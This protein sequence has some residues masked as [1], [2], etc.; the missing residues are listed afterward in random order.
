METGAID[1][2]HRNG[3]A[4]HSDLQ[5]PILKRYLR[6]CREEGETLMGSARLDWSRQWE[7]PFVLANLPADGI[8]RRILD[9]GC[10]YRFFAPL[11]A[12]RGFDV[13]ACDLDAS[14]GP[15]YDEVAARFDIAIEFSQ[16]DLAKLAY[17]DERFDHICCISVLEHAHDPVAIIREFRRCLKVG[18][19]LLLTFD[20]SVRGDRDIPVA[21]AR[22]LVDLLEREFAFVTPFAHRSLF[23]PSVLV[24]SEEVL[25]TEWFRR[26]HPDLLPWRF[27]SRAGLKNLL[28]GRIGRP[29]FDLTV[30]GLVLRKEDQRS[31][32]SDAA[33]SE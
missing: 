27:V 14:I 32:G 21:A 17:P 10:G 2:P 3:F 18:G 25:R 12:R 24:E 7:Y 29:F 28:R 26:Y 13:D 23:D 11:L 15:K 30:V 19:T 8:G 20:V 6:L 31:S 33:G 22:D 4:L 5:N 9:A 16:Q 1:F